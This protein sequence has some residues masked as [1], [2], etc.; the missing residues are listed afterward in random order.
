M[1]ALAV[2]LQE[3]MLSYKTYSADENDVLK[4]TA[5]LNLREKIHKIALDH[6]DSAVLWRPCFLTQ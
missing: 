3:I 5:R 6:E 4:V 1:V 2:P